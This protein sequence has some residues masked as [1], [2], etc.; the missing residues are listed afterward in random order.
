MPINRLRFWFA[1]LSLVF[2]LV[3]CEEETRDGQVGS[4]VGT[5]Q[6][7][8]LKVDWVR[9][10][11]SPEGTAP[12][13]GYTITASWDAAFDILGSDSAEADQILATFAVGDT[14]LDT[15]VVLNATWLALMQISMTVTFNADFTYTLTGTY[16]TLL[17]DEDSCKTVF[18][19]PQISDAGTYDVDYLKGRLAIIPPPSGQVLLSFNNGQIV[20]S[21][22]GNT[23]TIAFTDLNG[24]DQR[25][26]ETGETW[27]EAEN[28]VVHGAAEL[29]VDIVTGA[30]SETGLLGR[31]GYI[32]DPSGRLATWSNYVTFY[33]LMITRAAEELIAI[34]EVSTFEEALVVIGQWADGGQNEPDTGISYANLLTDDSG[35]DFDPADMPAGGKLTYVINPVCVPV[36]EVIEFETT[37][38]R[39]E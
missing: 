32:M 5:W 3:A 26:A 27:N 2:V 25:I 31:S 22:G 36:N 24:H 39:I 11:A 38:N 8:A 16:P 6:L 21:D 4:L 28:R 13:T 35:R 7:T 37:W 33:A 34:G 15:T 29:P 9:D 19:T 30:F 23:L 1:T 14:I 10:I 12:D 20:F 17:L 18:D